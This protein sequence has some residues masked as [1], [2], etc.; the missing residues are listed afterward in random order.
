[1]VK[2][3]P[4]TTKKQVSNELEAAG[5]QVSVYSQVYFTSR[6][7]RGCRVRKKLLIQ[8]GHVKA[9]LK[10][11]TDHMAKEKTF[12]R[13]TLWSHETNTDLFDH[14]EQQYVRRREG[15]AFNPEN[16]RPTV[17]HGAA[18]IMLWGCFAA[19]GSA[20]LKKVNE[21]MTK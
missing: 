9:G 2:S 7:L 12:E 14:N 21:R 5:R 17:Q 6:E 11:A 20:A 3:Q 8:T 19:G 4:K 16:T 15:E 13:K 1:M 18:S 10:F